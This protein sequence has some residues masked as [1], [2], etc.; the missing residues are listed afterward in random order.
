MVHGV[1]ASRPQSRQSSG[2]GLLSD[3]THPF[4]SAF[5][6]VTG[7]VS[8]LATDAG[9]FVEN[10]FNP[11]PGPNAGELS[12]AQVAT[13]NK[14]AAA[15]SPAAR[16]A[17]AYNA[18]TRFMGGP[19]SLRTADHNAGR[20]AAWDY[21]QA[22]TAALD[23]AKLTG[24]YKDFQTMS[25]NLQKYQKDG[26]YAPST[27]GTH[28]QGDNFYDDNAWIGLAYAQAYKQTGNKQYLS[29]AQGVFDFLQKGMHNGGLQ[30][31]QNQ[32]PPTW[33]TC[34]EGPAAELALRLHMATAQNPHSTNDK[35]VQFAT[36][37]NNN[38]NQHLRAPNGM[39]YDNVNANNPSQVSKGTYT[40]NQGTPIGVN[41]LMYQVTGDKKYLQQAQQTAT[42]SLQYFQ[43]GNKLW[44]KSP[45]FNAIYFRNLL[46]LNAVA[47][48]PHITQ[49]LSSYTNQLW[50]RGR[51][52]ATDLFGTG[53]MGHY[54]AP[55]S[56]S[57]I[58]LLDQAG[59]AQLFAMQAWPQSADG[60]LS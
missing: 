52:P 22:M 13:F 24:N 12:H 18:M 26:G 7:A 41:T 29:H 27:N 55:P 14:Q 45:A 59:V 51:T 37:L 57:Q 42:S 6:H 28:G 31:K 44:Q 16:S 20:A 50:T 46:Q 21:G 34:A 32:N 2:G 15:G 8:G 58:S 4:T 17:L 25:N 54:S 33:N 3:I 5:S 40:Y 23:H 56:G 10:L 11:H 53:G 43:Q 39:Y 38:M 48:D 49:A 19:A 35:Y 9:H 47:P 36:Q 1:G 60:T 30:W